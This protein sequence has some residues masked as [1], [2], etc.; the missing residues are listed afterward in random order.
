MKKPDRH[1]PAPGKPAASPGG[2]IQGEGDYAADRRYRQRTERFLGSADVDKLAH[3]AAPRSRADAAELEAAEKAG[4]ARAR[5]PKPRGPSAR[6][7]P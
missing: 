6:K 2:K 3:E 7:T 5:T 1:T 4:R